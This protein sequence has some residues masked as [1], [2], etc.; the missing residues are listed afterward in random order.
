MWVSGVY[1]QVSMFS[2]LASHSTSTGGKSVL[3]PSPYSI[4]MALLDAAIRTYGVEQGA[5]YFSLLRDMRIALSTP[6]YILVNN[7]FVRIQKPRRPKSHKE[8][9]GTLPKSEPGDGEE[10]EGLGPFIQ[11]I[12][13]REY[14]Q[15]SGPLGISC[16]VEQQDDAER[17]TQ[18][19][20]LVNY[21]GKRG[22][23]FQLDA[24]PTIQQRLPSRYAY[25][26]L[27]GQE[28]SISGGDR[29]VSTRGFGGIEQ[30]LDDW[31]PE[32][33]FNQVNTFSSSPLVL[34]RERLRQRVILPYAIARSSHGFTLYQKVTP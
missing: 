5:T 15:Y 34:G 23:F 22:G 25:I 11:S 19:F 17:L 27:D 10:E 14:I 1:H 6:Q 33:L 20:P 31:S 18:L 13:F 24:L 12:A 21:F 30:T 16:R 26:S 8:R 3:V 2:L 28:E 9:I 7:C 4:K 29:N 32:M